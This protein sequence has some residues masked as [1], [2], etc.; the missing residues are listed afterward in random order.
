MMFSG[1]TDKIQA[2]SRV[3]ASSTAYNSSANNADL[4]KNPSTIWRARYNTGNQYLTFD[5]N[6]QFYVVAVEMKG[7]QG[8]YVKS[9]YIKY[10]NETVNQLIDYKVRLC[11]NQVVELRCVAKV[12]LITSI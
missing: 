5:F 3:R 11:S 9:F 6:Q 12:Y 10:Y 8:H 2:P 7:D 4:T 1:D